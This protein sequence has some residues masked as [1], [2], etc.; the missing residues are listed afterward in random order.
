MNIRDATDSE[1]RQRYQTLSDRGLENSLEFKKVDNEMIR[2]H[3]EKAKANGPFDPK[4]REAIFKIKEIAEKNDLGIYCIVA[5]KTHIEYL[6]CMDSPSWSNIK[7]KPLKDGKAAYILQHR[8]KS[9]GQIGHERSE[10]TMGMIFGFRDMVTNTFA[11]LDG[12]CK[13]FGKALGTSH[14]SIVGKA[15]DSFPGDGKKPTL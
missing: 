13:E 7:L 3:D 6:H 15:P 8:G 12:L 2:R 1:L 11:I 14:T 9:Q 10:A 5:S 4:C